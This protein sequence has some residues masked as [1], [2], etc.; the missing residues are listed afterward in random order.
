MFIKTG[1]NKFSIIQ[2]SQAYFFVGFQ[3]H[4]KAKTNILRHASYICEMKIL[5]NLLQ[6]V[7]AKYRIFRLTHSCKY[8]F[9]ENLTKT[10]IKLDNFLVLQRGLYEYDYFVQ[11]FDLKDKFSDD[12]KKILNSTNNISLSL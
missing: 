1:F 7:N 8:N 5:G 4:L 11:N 2:H 12:L 10:E 6:R 3:K 9:P